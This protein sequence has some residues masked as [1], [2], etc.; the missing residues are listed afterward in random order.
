MGVPA[1]P[2]RHRYVVFLT[3]GFVGNEPEILSQV[4]A[5]AEAER[6]LGVRT[7]VFGL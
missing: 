5:Y 7:R 3:D 2:T 1:A 6:E 4:R